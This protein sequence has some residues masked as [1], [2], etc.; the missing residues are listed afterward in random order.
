M[1]ALELIVNDIKQKIKDDI[2]NGNSSKVL[3]ETIKNP[4]ESY[5]GYTALGMPIGTIAGIAYSLL[6]GDHSVFE[7]AGYGFSLGALSGFT[8]GSLRGIFDMGKEKIREYKCKADEYNRNL[9]KAL[10]ESQISI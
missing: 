8:I 2:I 9:R 3:R 5:F 6:S 4:R 7:D 1:T 10:I